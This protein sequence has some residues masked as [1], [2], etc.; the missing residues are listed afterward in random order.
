MDFAGVFAAGV[1]FA[2]V[3][4]AGVDLAGVFAAVLV[5]VF[6][7]TAFAAAGF[8]VFFGAPE[9]GVFAGLGL[10]RI[11]CFRLCFYAAGQTAS[12]WRD[13]GRGRISVR[14]T[15]HPFAQF[16][17]IISELDRPNPGE[18][19]PVGLLRFEGGF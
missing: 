5:A 19:G 16:S 8:V 4:A 15:I 6:V 2:G 13:E 18:T 17:S 1:D 7:A 10:I 12:L 3:F 14:K 11:S 9:A